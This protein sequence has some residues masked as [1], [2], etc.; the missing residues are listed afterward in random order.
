MEDVNHAPV[1]DHAKIET[2]S[3]L[4]EYIEAIIWAIFLF[5]IIKTCVVQSFKIPSSSME[6]TLLIGDHLMVTSFYLAS[7]YLLQT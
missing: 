5:L 7:G 1:L 4:R 2:K 6:D 3:K